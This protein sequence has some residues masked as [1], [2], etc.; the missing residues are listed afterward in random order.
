MARTLM[1]RAHLDLDL[2][3]ERTMSVVC[4]LSFRHSRR[5]LSDDGVPYA[6]W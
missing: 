5:S 3:A 1:S 4:S 2:A 6:I